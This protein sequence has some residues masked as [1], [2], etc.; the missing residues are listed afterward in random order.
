MI[1]L[2]TFQMEIRLKRSI[3]LTNEL[4]KYRQALIAATIGL[5]YFP[6]PDE[7]CMEKPSPELDTLQM[8]L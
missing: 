8:D 6:P 5:I 4:R 1:G 3:E 2:V 7:S